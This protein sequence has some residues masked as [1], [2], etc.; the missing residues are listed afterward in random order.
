MWEIGWSFLATLC[1]GG[2]VLHGN[3]PDGGMPVQNALKMAQNAPKMGVPIGVTLL[4]LVLAWR[5][6]TMRQPILPILA[7]SQF[8]SPVSISPTKTPLH[9]SH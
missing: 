5:K 9:Q 1:R 8:R 3:R 7:A 6:P 4:S 2:A